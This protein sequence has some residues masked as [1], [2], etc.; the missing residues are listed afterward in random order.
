LRPLPGRLHRRARAPPRVGR[1]SLP[2]LHGH[3]PDGLRRHD[4]AMDVDGLAHGPRAEHGRA[5]PAPLG[6]HAVIETMVAVTGALIA[7]AVLWWRD[8]RGHSGWDDLLSSDIHEVQALIER[9]F[10][11]EERV[12]TWSRNEWF[13]SELVPGRLML[14][15]RFA[16][17]ARIVA[18]AAPPPDR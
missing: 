17:Y 14:V 3:G 2:N 7:I 8:A 11:A 12:A 13:I 4:G 15:R 16:V 5:R 18:A 10:S 9:K 6:V 1:A